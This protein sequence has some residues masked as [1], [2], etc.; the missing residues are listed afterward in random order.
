MV[1]VI[2]ASPKAVMMAN[3]LMLVVLVS[4]WRYKDDQVYAKNYQDGPPIVALGNG[5]KQD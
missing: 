1:A 3:M 5:P 4:G 2:S